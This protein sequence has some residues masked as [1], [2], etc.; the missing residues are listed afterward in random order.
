MAGAAPQVEWY[1]ARDG[2]QYGPLSDVEMRKFV[3]LG[4]L[5]PADLVWR[6]GFPDWRPAPAVFP[7]P[8]PIPPP[9]PPR[10]EPRPASRPAHHPAAARAASPQRGYRTAAPQQSHR[11]VERAAP[12]P[13]QLAV[14]ASFDDE[15]D[16]DDEDDDLQAE[17]SRGLGRRI[18]LMLVLVALLGGAGW[19]AMGYIENPA[20]L[21][22]LLRTETRS[23]PSAEVLRSQ[24]FQGLGNSAEE[25][26]AAFQ[27]AALWQVIKRE[28]PDWYRER[29]QQ[30]VEL[31]AKSSDDATVARRL[32]EA[33]VALRRKHA[34]QALAA[35]PGALRS[36]AESFLANLEHLSAHSIEAC[37]G[38]ISQGEIN[39]QVLELMGSPEYVQPLQRQ[40]T[41]VFSAVAEGR[42][43]PQTH[44][45]P[46]QS[47]YQALK[48]ALAARGWTEK[49]EQLFSDPQALARAAP[50]D[51]CRLV[52][53][54]FA[55][56]L[57]IADRG[58]QLRLLI[59]SL[60]PVVAG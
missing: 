33:V 16:H 35:S 18:G 32:A 28:F 49:E 12:A 44:L 4:H 3:E 52:Q 13:S 45:P 50:Q 14:A 25:I 41:A 57:S 22:E 36:I 55:A 15:R 54:W 58:V 27:R 29:L 39:P 5:R 48:Q 9:A 31:K 23:E 7:T 60:K 56:Q 34:D 30:A 26:D 21:V 51:V 8:A 46:R 2:Q 17:P 6:Q 53:D 40:V 20:R 38:F 59:E 10:P 24:P 37:Y 1:I 42:K 11:A 47:D 19:L 43:S